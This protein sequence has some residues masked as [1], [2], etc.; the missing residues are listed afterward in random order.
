MRI[1]NETQYSTRA[2]RSVLTTIHNH[3]A[4]TEGRMRRWKELVVQI[5]YTRDSRVRGWAYLGNA[6]SGPVY[7]R[8]SA[9]GRQENGVKI[10]P[11]KQCPD[12]LLRLPEPRQIQNDEI[13]RAD[14]HDLGWLTY[15]EFMHSYGY[16]H[17]QYTDIPKK[18]LAML[19]PD[20]RKLPSK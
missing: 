4:K 15:H 13:W 17:K 7:W 2:I 10:E 1:K 18:E 11:G 5:G 16:N 3:M 20:N 14:E 19:F 8:R 6:N 12:V 9:F